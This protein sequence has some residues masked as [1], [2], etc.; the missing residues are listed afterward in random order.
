[1]QMRQAPPMDGKK[2]MTL[3][4]LRGRHLWRGSQV[5]KT[6]WGCSRRMRL[7]LGSR[8]TPWWHAFAMQRTLNRRKKTKF[9]IKCVKCRP[10]RWSLRML[11]SLNSILN[12]SSSNFNSREWILKTNFK[13]NSRIAVRCRYLRGRKTWK[14]KVL[15]ANVR[16]WKS[17][18]RW[19][20]QVMMNLPMK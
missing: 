9:S 8:M 11:E 10:K 16:A 7:N 6:R 17:N 14:V 5:C 1:M 2:E 20:R 13:I 19:Y 18:Y 4:T 15:G 3:L 12:K